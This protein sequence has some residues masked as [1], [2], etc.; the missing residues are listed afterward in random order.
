MQQSAGRLRPQPSNRSASSGTTGGTGGLPDPRAESRPWPERGLLQLS[1]YIGAAGGYTY[2]T[3]FPFLGSAR[4]GVGFKPGRGAVSSAETCSSLSPAREQAGI[5][6]AS[7]AKDLRRPR[8]CEQHDLHPRAEPQTSVSPLPRRPLAGGSATIPGVHR[9][10]FRGS[11]A[12]IVHICM[13]PLS[14]TRSVFIRGC[15]TMS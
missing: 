2:R 15:Q 7:P 5:A 4:S 13:A 1:I 6:D 3:M 14:H 9:S 11:R 8:S 12:R 10:S